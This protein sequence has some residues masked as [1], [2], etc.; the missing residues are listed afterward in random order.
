MENVNYRELISNCKNIEELN[1]LK[2][3]FLYECKEREDNLLVEQLLNKITDF[4]VA[5]TIFESMI[6]SLLSKKQGKNIINKYVKTLKENNSLKTLYTYCDGLSK[7]TTVESKKS[8]IV[9]ALSIGTLVKNTD[10]KCGVS[11]MVKLI[12]EAF[13]MLGNKFVLENITIDNKI[14][15]ISESLYYLASTKKDIRNLNDYISHIDVVCENVIKT[16]N[17]DSVDVDKTLSE[18]VDNTFNNK[19]INDIFESDNKELTFEKNK[20]VCLEMISKQKEQNEDKEVYSKLNEME[21]K[22]KNKTYRFDTYTKDIL[23]MTELQELL[24]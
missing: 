13:K 14:K 4:G 20:Q 21:S 19:N 10:Y 9:E 7:N 16:E 15:N 8:Y 12:S 18:I 23:Y 24:K 22:L 6:P 11:N 3:D 17:N 1:N 5:K 2:N